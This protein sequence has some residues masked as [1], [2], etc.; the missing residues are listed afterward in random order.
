MMFFLHNQ[1]EYI[2]MKKFIFDSLFIKSNKYPLQK[3]EGG[4]L[5]QQ[6]AEG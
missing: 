2:C 3:N 5:E 4:D 6:I 1:M